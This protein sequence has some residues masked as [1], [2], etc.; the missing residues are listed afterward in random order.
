[1]SS[2]GLDWE[3]DGGNW[4]NRA[5]SLFVEASGIR[6][7]VQRAGEGP[8]ALLLHGT[9]AATHSWRGLFPL[10]CRNFT[11][12]AP[13]LP[14]HGF[15]GTPAREG[16]ALPGMASEIQQL[17]QALDLS[18]SLAVGHSA[19][20]AILVTMA[21]ENRIAPKLIVGINAALFPFQGVV[22]QFF[23]PLAKLLVLNPVVP[24]LFA[25]GASGSVSVEKLIRD[26]GSNIDRE[27]IG[28]Y[29]LLMQSASHVTGALRMM[30]GW[31]LHSLK[32]NMPKLSTPLML[33]AGSQDRSIPPDQAFAVQDVLPGTKVEYL[34][35][36]GHLAH[37][38]QPEKIAALIT[39]AAR[40]HGILPASAIT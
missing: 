37:E 2:P 38:E 17:L 9:G 36:L 1:M 33:I 40:Q 29:Q 18:P 35:G 32:R 25:W 24:R 8:V 19:G 20:A 27:G 39:D 15:T 28:Q 12:I 26:T 16:L 5:A 34:R 13:D 10:L 23:S 14:G 21:L 6:W 3:R 22:S 7:H 4:P 11:V 31:D 30:A